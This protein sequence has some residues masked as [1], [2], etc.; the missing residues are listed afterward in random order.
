[1]SLNGA[2]VSAASKSTSDAGTVSVSFSEGL[3]LR[4]S[5]VNTTAQGGNG[6]AVA[7]RGG[8]N[9]LLDNSQ[10]LSSA[11]GPTG[12]AGDIN[13]RADTLRLRTGF[14]QANSAAA[15]GHGGDVRIRVNHLVPSFGSLYLGG[16]TP[17]AF[18]QG[19][20]GLNVIQAAAPNGTPGTVQILPY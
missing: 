12:D 15:G 18:Q 6:G 11:L 1:M 10:V 20:P 13:V 7:F 16:N 14:I 5:I 19:A 17:I 2:Q 8:R 9:I 4:N 3:S